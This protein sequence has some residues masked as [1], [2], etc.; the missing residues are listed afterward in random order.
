MNLAPYQ[1]VTL[2]KLLE[3]NAEAFWRL[4][5]VIGQL[6]IRLE[7]RQVSE[8]M[9][10]IA[11]RSLGEFDRE[12]PKL[13]LKLA[14][15]QM[16]R[17]KVALIGEEHERKPMSDIGPML[18]DLHQR[19]CDDLDGRVFLFMPEA[20][21]PYYQPETPLF[22]DEVESK[23]PQASEDIAEAGK[24]LALGRPTAAIFH[25]MRVMEIG[26]QT[27]GDKLG[28]T[29]AS[30]KNWQNILNEVNKSIKAMD[31]KAS[32]TKAYAAASSHLYNVKLAWRNEVMHPKQTYTPD[33]AVTVFSSVG[34]FMRDLALMV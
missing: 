25:L 12:L 16:A 20:A 9:M 4:S 8:N 15:K 32:Q 3:T 31:P 26:T 19:I 1:L 30:E 6:F 14:S 2:L 28:V 17:I 23:F 27:F 10:S 7:N 18:K 33:E 34:A 13:S 21:V 24:C 5:S 22:G 29:L 11:A